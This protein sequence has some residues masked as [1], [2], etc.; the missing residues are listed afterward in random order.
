MN[1]RLIAVGDIHGCHKE[2]EDLLDKLDLRKDDRL[3]LLGDLI[4]RGPDSGKVVELAR[5]YAT[6]SLLGNHE[7][8]H[9]NYRRTDD[10]THLKKYDYATMEQLRGKDW[11]Y[12][13]EMKL[14]YEDEE[15]GVVFVHGGFLP[16]RPWQRQPARIVTRIQVVGKDGEPHKRSEMPDAPHWS[17]LWEGPPFVVYGHTPREDVVR[18][19]W[20][21][22]IDTACVL[23]G[24]LTAYILPEKKIVQVKARETYFKR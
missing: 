22:G 24:F 9:L 18:T 16:D 23:G 14:T 7:L 4:S 3:I 10:P 19:K 2:F 12:L 15:L 11:D 5:K 1:G 20:T 17:S 13:E 8:R 6:A 21:L